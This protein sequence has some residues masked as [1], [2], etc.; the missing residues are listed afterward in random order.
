M[1]SGAASRTTPRAQAFDAITPDGTRTAIT[2]PIAE[3][4]PVAIEVNGIG[5][6][7]LMATADALE[8]LALE[9]A[10]PPS[11]VLPLSVLRNT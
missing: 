11:H 8:D 10:E 2:R 1:A 6:A 7:V 5:Y 9:C 3:E 4:I